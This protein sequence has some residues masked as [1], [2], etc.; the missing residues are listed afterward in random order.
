MFIGRRKEIQEI[1]APDGPNLLYGGR[2]LGKTAILRRVEYL[3]NRPAEGTWASYV[4]IRDMNHEDAVAT[5]SKALLRSGFFPST[6]KPKTWKEL[7]DMIESQLMDNL[8][9][10]G[11]SLL[12]MMDEADHILKL[13]ED[14]S[15]QTLGD[16]KRLQQTTNGR[17]KFVLA[18]LH[19]VLRFSNSEKALGG[20]SVLPHLG[21]ITIQPMQFSDGRELL[22]VPLSYLGF[23]ID[24]G[25]ED[26][27]AQ[28][29]YN[30]NYFPGLIHFYAR[31]LVEHM[32]EVAP[33][34]TMPPYKLS[35]DVLLRMIG[36]ESFRKQRTEKLMMTL[37]VDEK[38]QD[39]YYYTLAYALAVSSYDSDDV[40]LHGASASTIKALCTDWS[41]NC[42]IGK[43]TDQQI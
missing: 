5:I 33:E 8:N 17:F 24:Q 1:I 14:D 7:V 35:R 18:G 27:I 37:R 42:R 30:T 43:L 13:F 23:T 28:I 20:N 16:M 36:E 40:L 9:K 15:F 39:A 21:G 3:R 38:D 22:E 26:I 4:D 34:L 29:L 12:L 6:A 25:Q 19:N 11:H 10:N 32:K 41:A 2:Q 31:R